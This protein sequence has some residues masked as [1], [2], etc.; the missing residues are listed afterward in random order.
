MTDDEEEWPPDVM[1]WDARCENCGRTHVVR[2]MADHE[3][4]DV[5][6]HY[7]GGGRACH[8]PGDHTLLRRLDGLA[9]MG[10]YPH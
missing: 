3:A 8:E 7:H 5:V 9:R 6:G 4:G 10:T 2:V 1:P